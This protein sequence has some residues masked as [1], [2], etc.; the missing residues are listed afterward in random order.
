MHEQIETAQR[1]T[2][3]RLLPNTPSSS[4]I[5]LMKEENCR[6]PRRLADVQ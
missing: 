5:T 2:V 4:K 1:L 3:A 6:L